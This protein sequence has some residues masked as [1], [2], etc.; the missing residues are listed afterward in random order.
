MDVAPLHRLGLLQCFTFLVEHLSAL[1][2]IVDLL[3]DVAPAVEHRVG[4]GQFAVLDEVRHLAV[5]GV[6]LV[7]VER[8]IPL[9]HVLDEPFVAF[10]L[11]IEL[12]HRVLVVFDRDFATA[13]Q[14]LQLVLLGLQLFLQ[15]APYLAFGIKFVL[16]LLLRC[17]HEDVDGVR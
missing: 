8:C 11:G 9:G 4:L 15:V 13:L 6:E 5:E 12:L 14:R 1:S 3:T 7:I 16:Q 10:L 17:L 2:D